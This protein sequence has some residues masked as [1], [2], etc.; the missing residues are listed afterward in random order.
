MKTIQIQYYHSPAGELILGSFENKLCLCD[1]MGR[2]QRER[3]DLRIKKSLEAEYAIAD[4][5]VLKQAVI[6]LDQYFT[7]QRTEFDI[8]LLFAGTDFQK[9]V[10]RT[11]LDISYG[12]TISYGDMARQMG[13]PKSVRAVANAN[14]ANAI[15]IFAPC[16]R[17]IGGNRKLVGYAGGLEAKRVLLEIEG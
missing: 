7:R 4:S 8:P 13:Y 5:S 1:W 6:E 12:Q 10:W 16:H 9:R 11:L 15:A 14:G 2:K 17:V 3:I